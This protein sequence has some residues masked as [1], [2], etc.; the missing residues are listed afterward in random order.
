[1]PEAE[2]VTERPFYFPWQKKKIVA[3]ADLIVEKY[4][5]GEDI[6]LVGFSLGGLIACAVMP[7]F[8]KSKVRMVV[9][10][11]APHRLSFFYRW[12]KFK[13]HQLPV[14]VVT[15][16]GIFDLV[17]LWFLTRFPGNIRINLPSDHF[18]LFL[19]SPWPARRIASEVA[20]R[21]KSGA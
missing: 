11:A 12:L 13:P 8:K 10:I 19:F 9:T 18:I 16:V 3:L 6:V 14:P 15:F 5:T 1:M 4:D 2:F 20:A 21:L 7:R 17:S